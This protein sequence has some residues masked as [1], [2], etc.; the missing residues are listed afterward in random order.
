MKTQFNF[1]ICILLFFTYLGCT[2]E[3]S[4]EVK[5]SDTLSESEEEALKFVGK[6]IRL[7]SKDDENSSHFLHKA[8]DMSADCE[9][10]SPTLGFSSLDYDKES[11]V[12]TTD[13][14]LEVQE[15][16]LFFDG[17]KVEFQVDEFLCEYV[18]YKPYR[19]FGFQPGVTTKIQYQVSCDTS[20]SNDPTITQ[21]CDNTYKTTGAVYNSLNVYD[22][23]NSN[24][25]LSD[26][27]SANGY[28]GLDLTDPDLA[29][30]FSNQ[31]STEDLTTCHFNYT[32]IY[33]LLDGRTAPNCD[34]GTVTTVP[35]EIVGIEVDN[36][37]CS[38]TMY[39]T[40]ATCIANAETWT[41]N[42]VTRCDTTVTPTMTIDSANKTSIECG[43]DFANCLAGPGADE[44]PSGKD[45]HYII[46]NT[47]EADFS[48]AITLGAPYDKNLRSNMWVANFSRICSSTSLTKD[49]AEF[50]TTLNTIY[51]YEVEDLVERST[52]NGVGIDED[53]DGTF[54]YVPLGK[55]LFNGQGAY[56][57]SSSNV[58]P[59]Y[60][61]KCLDQAK[62]VKAQI[63]LFIRDWDRNFSENN[64]YVG[65]LSDINQS[66]PLMDSSGDQA[67]GEYWNDYYDLDD[68]LGNY[69]YDTDDDDNG[70]SSNFDEIFFNNQCTSM[71]YGHCFRFTTTDSATCTGSAVTGSTNPGTWYRRY[72]RYDLDQ[73]ADEE[74]CIAA[75]GSWSLAWCSDTQYLNEEDCELND[76]SW[77][78]PDGAFPNDFL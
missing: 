4:E 38:D 9:L 10:T 59:Y 67:V 6:S 47:N 28:F 12:Y 18:Q 29:N 49:I 15:S 68:L 13:C 1:L 43:G 58:Q 24:T 39:T 26:I 16:D 23:A 75:S 21:F 51:G 17:A 69:D 19:F 42:L 76:E 56:S 65:R 70:D 41:A 71:A 77:Y 63:R 20:C 50:D 78:K 3:I 8:G 27:N 74:S 35:V 61:L 54:D 32:D 45:N 37:S 36:G 5:N 62:D 25:A 57:I 30:L 46:P 53:G 55:H 73:I 33:E 34:E 11:S 22:A 2:N 52:Y 60:A 14:V 48:Y 72:C 44:F 7:V 64:A 31:V 66:T 40:E